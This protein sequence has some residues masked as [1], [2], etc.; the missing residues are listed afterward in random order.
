MPTKITLIAMVVLAALLGG[1]ATPGLSPTTYSGS[2][3]SMR[4]ETVIFGTVVAVRQITIRNAGANMPAGAAV[5][6][7]GGAAVGSAIGNTKG[8]IIGGLVGL[9]A[10]T[11]VGSQT[12]EPGVL[13][14]VR[15]SDGSAS[16]IPQPASPGM[17]PF[18]P[19]E[20]VQILEGPGRT[21]VLPAA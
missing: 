20:R 7:L 8:A 1:C 10:G 9:L 4:P 5:G 19:G 14:T 6:G 21:R 15:F 18:Y 16:A 17:Q 11:A 13:V 2:Q 3:E 12:T